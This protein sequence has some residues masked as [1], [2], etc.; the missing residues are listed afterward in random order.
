MPETLKEELEGFEEDL[1]KS[2]SDPEVEI[3][4]SQDDPPV[5][6][7]K[8][9]KADLDTKDPEKDSDKPVVEPDPEPEGD[10]KAPETDDPEPKDAD[11]PAPKLTTLPDDEETFGEL[12]GKEVTAEQLIGAGLLSKLVTWGH[13]GRHMVQKGQKDI[14]AAK[15]EKSEAE[16]LREVLEKRFEKE[17]ADAAK[18]ATPPLSEKDFAGALVE[19]Y[20]PGLNTIA[21]SGGI[22]IDFLKEFPKA[23]SHIEHR[24]QGGADVLQGL[25]KEVGEL[26]DKVGKHEERNA[27]AE[28]AEATAAAEGHFEGLMSGLAENGGALFAGLGEAET[29]TNFVKWLTSDETSMRITDKEVT[30]ITADDVQGAWLVYANAHPGVLAPK[31]EG[32][33]NKDADLAGGGGGRGS[34]KSKTPVPEDEMSTFVKELAEAD[35]KVE[36]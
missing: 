25:I 14:E 23:A 35:A 28:K 20:L 8:G 22:E 26:R 21:E 27:G 31:K 32:G 24:F 7:D 36:Y 6:D 30:D 9:Q 5:D 12:A 18:D 19:N 15:V 3:P 17:D 4:E 10:D 11:D 29:K 13:Q 2:I 33:R 16:K 34:S 1:A